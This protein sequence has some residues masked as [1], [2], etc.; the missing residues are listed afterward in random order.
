MVNL[1]APGL[2]HYD[3]MHIDGFT[4]AINPDAANSIAR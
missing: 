3:P 4:L 2:V 1:Q